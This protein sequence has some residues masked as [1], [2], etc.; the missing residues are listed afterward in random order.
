[1]LVV[2]LLWIIYY[3]MG[4][5]WSFQWREN[6]IK[7]ERLANS[8]A[9]VIHDGLMNITIWKVES[10]ITLTGAK[11]RLAIGTGDS[12]TG[13]VRYQYGSNNLFQ[14][15]SLLDEDSHYQVDRISWNGWVITPTGTTDKLDI[16]LGQNERTFSGADVENSATEIKIRV[17]YMEKTKTV[18]F[19][20]RTGRVEVN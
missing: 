3:A 14:S 2:V 15:I 6:S 16:I 10:G 4:S 12:L 5:F 7:A 9:D 8:I 18:T 20:R 19:D 13:M 11:I 17:R 1:M